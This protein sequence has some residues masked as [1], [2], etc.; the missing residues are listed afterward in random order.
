MNGSFLERPF[1][2]M[3][4]VNFGTALGLF[5]AYRHGYRGADLLFLSIAAVVTLN[6]VGLI[7]ILSPRKA[8]RTQN[9]F[10]KPLWIAVGLLW[11]IYLLDW[12]FPVTSVAK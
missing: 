5:I 6:A 9:R 2:K 7:G 4:L 12:M 8:V 1:G 3:A 10:L 11:L